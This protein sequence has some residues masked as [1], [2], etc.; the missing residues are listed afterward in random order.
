MPTTAHAEAHKRPPRPHFEQPPH[1]AA[2][3]SPAAAASFGPVGWSGDRANFLRP[4]LHH[5]GTD[6]GAGSADGQAHGLSHWRSLSPAPAHAL[7]GGARAPSWVRLSGQGADLTHGGWGHPGGGS[8][9]ESRGGGDG[10]WRLGGGGVGGGGGMG[11][12]AGGYFGVGG[13]GDLTRARSAPFGRGIGRA[14]S[15]PTP[16]A[17]Q[18]RSTGPF[19]SLPGTPGSPG[20]AGGAEAGWGDRGGGGGPCVGGGDVWVQVPRL[21]VRERE[22]K[23]ERAV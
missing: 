13:S 12:R 2:Q 4:G 14:Q 1:S 3:L 8:D 9:A 17:A 19:R 5:L 20:W 10:D 22:R 15:A 6:G 23:K 11:G 18:H 7:P 16:T 21:G